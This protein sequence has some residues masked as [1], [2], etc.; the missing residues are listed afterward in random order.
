MREVFTRFS[1]RA[2]GSG[3]AILEITLIGLVLLLWF[4]PV[5][6]PGYGRDDSP[7]VYR[8]PTKQKVVAL[9]FDDGPHPTYTPE[10]LSILDHYHIKATFFMIGREMLK[11]PEIVREVVRRGHVVANHTFSHPHNIEAD[12]QAQVIRELDKCEEIIEQMTGRR[13]HLFRPPRGLVDGTVLQIADEEGYRTILWTVCADHHDA[14][15]PELM[16]RRVLKHVRSGGI[17]L[18]HDG[19]FCSRWK[20][21]KATPM[22]IEELRRRGYRFVT[23]PELLAMR[24]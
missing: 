20:D 11:H 14:P 9:T 4:R 10:I 24:R 17:V 8:V 22:I 12:S 6:A 3:R 7:V 13:A 23:I 18:A 16:T 1:A 15:T 19:T 5:G 21:V 2:L